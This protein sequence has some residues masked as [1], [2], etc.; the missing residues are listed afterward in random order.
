LDPA[1]V[2]GF[3]VSMSSE[4]STVIPSAQVSSDRSDGVGRSSEPMIAP[5]SVIQYGDFQC[6]ECGRAATTIKLFRERFRSLIRFEYL[7]F[8]QLFHEHAVQAAEAAECARAQRRFWPMHDLL[9]ANQDRLDLQFIYDYAEDIRLD[10]RRF[11][12]EMD[13]E[14]HLRKIHADANG[15]LEVGVYRTPTFLVNGRLVDISS[16]LSALFEATEH[17]ADKARGSNKLLA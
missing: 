16:G 11:T 2:I 17:A 8:P 14:V 5:V 9:M 3:S 4:S 1:I 7:H 13:D 12:T 15:G 10:M 6:L